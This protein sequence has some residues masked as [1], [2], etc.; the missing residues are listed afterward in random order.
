MIVVSAA[1]GAYGSLV[2][3]HLL[4][5]APAAQIAVAVRNPDKAADFATRGI[6]VLFADYDDP[7]SMRTAYQG[8]DRLLFISS[9]GPA[10]GSRT[11]QH[12]RVVD[13]AAHAG[14]G[15]VLYTSGV[16]ADVIRGRTA[17]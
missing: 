9:P 13:A 16:G 7:A 14:V 1:T 5:R 15:T 12:R 6:Q 2:V 11:V 3:D 17:R 10:T 8:A 4:N